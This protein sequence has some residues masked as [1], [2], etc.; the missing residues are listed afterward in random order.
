MDLINSNLNKQAVLQPE[1]I[2][3]KDDTKAI[4]YRELII[5]I[6]EYKKILKDICR[7]KQKR[8]AIYLPNSIEYVISIYAILNCNSIFIPFPYDSPAIRVMEIAQD[9]KPEIIITNRKGYGEIFS[10]SDIK[11]CKYILVDDKK[12][13]L[14]ENHREENQYEMDKL[15]LYQ[16]K[17]HQNELAY[18]VYTSGSTGMPKGVV[19]RYNSLLNFIKN[20]IHT[21]SLNSMTNYISMLPFNFDGS[22]G[23]IFAPLWVGGTLIIYRRNIVMP[24][25][26]IQKLQQEKVNFFGCTPALFNVLVDF[27]DKQ[28]AQELFLKTVSIGGDFIA[29]ESVKRFY[30][31]FE[32]VKL[33]N[34]YGPTETT[35]VVS[36][37]LIKKEDIY[38]NHPFPIGKPEKNNIFMALDENGKVIIPG[39][40][41][42]L[43]ISGCQ[44][45]S[46]YWND[47][48]L[49]SKV[50]IDMNGSSYYK[51]NDFV[52][53]TEEGEYILLGRQT[54]MIKRN[55]YR[56]F[57][58]EIESYI[59]KIKGI[60]DCLC[61]EIN[62]QIIAFCVQNKE[63]SCNVEMVFE[64]LKEM[65]PIYMIPNKIV[66]IDKLPFDSVGKINRRELELLV[67]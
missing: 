51:T 42:E 50:L 2:A 54:N 67:E 16:N 38:L 45:M 49:T 8:I 25:K 33:Y 47:D 14:Q 41:G 11:G 62:K 6:N 35:S 39:K 65:L 3:I 60:Y 34:R 46:G 56:I 52:T 19:I 1:K 20:T 44:V 37:Y 48:I 18:I 58:K 12:R 61:L 22:F 28:T 66:F 7:K 59:M 36:G 13:D 5:E 30:E 17:K 9:C 26:L 53:L 29:K 32:G 21:F 43:Y 23:G 24:H 57:G 55:G 31:L 4:T 40:V 10:V 27:L 64:Q 63:C 15:K